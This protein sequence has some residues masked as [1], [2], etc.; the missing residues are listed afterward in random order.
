[1]DE[2]TWERLELAQDVAAEREDIAA[3]KTASRAKLG[4]KRRVREL[5][6]AL[7]RSPAVQEGRIR[8]SLR[9]ARLAA[10][11]RKERKAVRGKR[12]RVHKKS[13]LREKIY[14]SDVYLGGYTAGTSIIDQT[15]ELQNQLTLSN[16]FKNTENRLLPQALLID[17]RG[18][19]VWAGPNVGSRQRRYDFETEQVL[20]SHLNGEITL[21]ASGERVSKEA[22]G[23][24][25]R[26]LATWF[27][28]DHSRDLTFKSTLSD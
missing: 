25:R 4:S 15:V 6:K 20:L 11:D 22:I 3:G 27:V 9:I 7:K 13:G 23:A 17:R 14:A 18:N 5:K 21:H 19:I 1:L 24:A 16:A 10:K 8:E 26:T 28:N 2:N 12:I